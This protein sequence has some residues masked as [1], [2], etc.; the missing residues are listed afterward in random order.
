MST[1]FPLATADCA[2]PQFFLRRLFPVLLIP[3]HAGSV[4]QVLKKDGQQ[5]DAYRHA[6]HCKDTAPHGRHPLIS[7]L[8][9]TV[10]TYSVPPKAYRASE[11]SKSF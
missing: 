11:M 5:Q 9:V 8:W 6:R 4:P 2:A 10:F 7:S 1:Q 3:Q